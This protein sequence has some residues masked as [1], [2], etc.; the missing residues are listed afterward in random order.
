METPGDQKKTRVA[1]YLIK[2]EPIALARARFGGGR[3][4]DS[5]K[6]LKVV[7]SIT[8]QSQHDLDPFFEGPISLNLSF[9]LPIVSAKK[10]RLNARPHTQAPDLDNLIKYI[11]DVASG[12]IYKDDRIIA[13][14]V[15]RKYYST[16]P[17]TEIIVSEIIEDSW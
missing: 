11:A 2:G 5:Q 14:I 1:R 8:L 9:Y 6:N 16:N 10:I 15:A 3:V 4:Y 17:R 12:I 7:T 13:C